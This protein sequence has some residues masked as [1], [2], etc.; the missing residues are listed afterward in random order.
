MV[1]A[2]ARTGPRTIYAFHWPGA[3]QSRLYGGA[4]VIIAL[5]RKPRF[6]GFLEDQC[7]RRWAWVGMNNILSMAVTRARIFLSGQICPVP[8]MWMMLGARPAWLGREGSSPDPDCGASR[9]WPDTY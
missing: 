3:G 1:A 8:I 9:R 6:T 5:F 2:L 4:A 7:H